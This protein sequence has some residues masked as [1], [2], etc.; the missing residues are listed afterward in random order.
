MF[1]LLIRNSFPEF[2]DINSF[3]VIL[4]TDNFPIWVVYFHL[5]DMQKL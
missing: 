2:K 5:F 1:F 4:I 3:A